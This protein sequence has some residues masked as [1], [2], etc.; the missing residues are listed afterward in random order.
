[1]KII[2][3][4][5]LA[6]ASTNID[7]IFLLILFFGDRT[8]KQL[9]IFLGQYL[10]VIILIAVSLIASIS[11]A[12]IDQRYIGLLGLFPVYLGL[13]KFIQLLKNKSTEDASEA[14]PVKFKNYAILSVAAV[15][16]A[17]GGDNIGIYT[18]LLSSQPLQDKFMMISIFMVMIFIWCII[19]KYLATHPLLAKTIEKYGAVFTPWIL[20]LL[21]FFILYESNSFSLV[22]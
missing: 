9:Q 7:D 20:I 14:I 3:T 1:M 4:S 10:G 22:F 16:C 18:P 17:N 12:F 8:Y 21:G 13:Q 15:T 6:F 11:A 19:A 2:W 5:I